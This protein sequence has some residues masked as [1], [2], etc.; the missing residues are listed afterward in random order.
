MKTVAVCATAGAAACCGLA[1]VGA[2]LSPPTYVSRMTWRNSASRLENE[3]VRTGGGFHGGGNGNGYVDSDSS[4]G[5][6][7]MPNP[8]RRAS[9]RGGNKRHRA[10]LLGNLD[11]KPAYRLFDTVP[12]PAAME[13]ERKSDDVDLKVDGKA[14]YGKRIFFDLQ[15]KPSTISSEMMCVVSSSLGPLDSVV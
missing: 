3:G 2:F 11:L 1:G 6:P 13:A 10:T 9:G 12:P 7:M 15:M 14:P 5:R 8:S 4:S